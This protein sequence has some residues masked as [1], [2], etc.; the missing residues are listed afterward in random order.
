[1]S[2]THNVNFVMAAYAKDI[3]DCNKK[4]PNCVYDVQV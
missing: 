1:M 3:A 4:D 2:T